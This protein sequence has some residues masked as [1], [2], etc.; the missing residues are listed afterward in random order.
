[1][2]ESTKIR[3]DLI[4]SPGCKHCKAFKEFWHSIEGDWP[5]VTFQDISVT[6]P[7]GQE[8][9]MKHMVFSAPGIVLNGELF[10]SGGF[11]SDK[12]LEKLKELSA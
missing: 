9:A 5:Q 10:A 6:T 11:D 4:S 3:I 7:E 8:L 2:G 1:M 12:F